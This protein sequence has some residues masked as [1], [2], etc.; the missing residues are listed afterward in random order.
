[1]YLLLTNSSKAKS[2]F[3]PKYF[4]KESKALDNTY[5]TS[6]KTEFNN[7]E[8]SSVLRI[9]FI[10]GGKLSIVFLVAVNNDCNAELA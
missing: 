8:V 2:L 9:L 10:A 1:M 7:L 3:A 6:S 5:L 4:N